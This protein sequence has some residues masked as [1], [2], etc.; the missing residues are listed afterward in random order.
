MKLGL[1]HYDNEVDNEAAMQDVMHIH[2]G[3]TST[4]ILSSLVW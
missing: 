4:A 3:F 2:V 1:V